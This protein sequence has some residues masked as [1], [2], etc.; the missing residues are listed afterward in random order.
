MGIP[1]G[2][3]PGF[4]LSETKGIEVVKN[5]INIIARLRQDPSGGQENNVRK[6]QNSNSCQQ[7]RVP[8]INTSPPGRIS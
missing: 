6:E 3:V 4:Q 7:C 8:G 2:K 1:Q 5:I